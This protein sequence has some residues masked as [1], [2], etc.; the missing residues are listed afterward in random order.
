MG[1]INPPP[2]RPIKPPVDHFMKSWTRGL[3]Q[4]GVPFFSAHTRLEDACLLEL[5]SGLPGTTE[6]N[7]ARSFVTQLISNA[8]ALVTLTVANTMLLN[9]DGTW[10]KHFYLVKQLPLL[11]NLVSASQQLNAALNAPSVNS[12]V[13][14]LTLQD[15]MTYT[16][17][18]YLV[19][20]QSMNVLSI[21]SDILANQVEIV[22]LLNR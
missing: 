2:T 6:V 8:N 22:D 19:R 3:W 10:H 11:T 18:N 1:G 21:Y 17:S 14:G 13:T 20:V 12:A 16:E 9:V 5:N 15:S 7:D 4:I